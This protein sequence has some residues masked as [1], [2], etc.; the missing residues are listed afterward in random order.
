MNDEIIET[1]YKSIMNKHTPDEWKIIYQKEYRNLPEVIKR[2]ATTKKEDIKHSRGAFSLS[3]K[4]NI[5]ERYYKT[6]QPH[7]IKIE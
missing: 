4:R 2:N 6:Q 3:I 5:V 1:L 7:A